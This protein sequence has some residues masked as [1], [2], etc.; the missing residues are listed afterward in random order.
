MK[1]QA[2]QVN[3]TVGDIEGNARKVVQALERA[4][5]GGIDVVLFPELVLCGYPPED[6]LLDHSF[7]DALEKKLREIAPA[8]KGL[9][10]AIGLPRRNPRKKE[11]GLC[12]SAAI[13][14]DGQ[15]VGFKDKTLLPTYDVFDERRFFEPGEQESVF[16]YLGWKIGVTICEDAWQHVG[17]VGYTDYRRDPIQDFA[18]KEIDLL[19]NLSASPYYFKRQ[20]ARL[21]VFEACAKTLRCPVVVCNQV[22]GNDQVVF[23]GH[24]LFVNEK[25]ELIQ[26]AKGF[27]E[28]DLIVD[29]STHACPC[30][31][32][33][34]GTRDLYS[35]LVLGVR[36]YFQKQGLSQAILGLSGGVDSTLVA[37]IAKDALGA[38][39]IKAYSLPS[40]FSSPNSY[41]DAEQLARNLGI[42]LE[43][44]SIDET[45]QH[46]LDW[47]TPLFQPT[48][49]TEQNLQPRIRGTLLMSISNQSGAILLNTGN[50]SE[51]AMGYMTLYGDMCGG[52]GVLLDVTKTQVYALARFLN[53]QGEVIPEAILQR[54]PSAELKENQTDQDTL[55][56]YDVLDPILEDYIEEGL[57]PQEIAIKHG[58]LLPFV[59]DVI[60]KI[61]LAEYKRRQAAIGIRVTQKCFS[62]GRNVPIVQRWR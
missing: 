46:M 34:N 19:L 15:L 53:R 60:H 41:T 40:R 16:E 22:G 32:P 42:S 45:F 5:K 1:I 13:F 44:I 7:I 4:R 6:L 54:V 23:D 31:L 38:D 58:H 10:A 43:K 48:D 36:D 62:K 29:S 59:K 9:F 25:G 2:S 52:L 3:P 30:G 24:S 12:N 35:A 56:P 33:E 57:S 39:K 11:K 8:T 17:D 20:D 47:I 55:P 21:S 14:I 61:H 26:L 49:L 50:K 37:C 18:E 28:D 27:V 51:L